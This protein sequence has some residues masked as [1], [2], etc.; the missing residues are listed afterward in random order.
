MPECQAIWLNTA[1]ALRK[2]AEVKIITPE[3][4][5]FM[6]AEAAAAASTSAKEKTD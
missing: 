5:A 6:A 4:E 2:G 3:E 1:L